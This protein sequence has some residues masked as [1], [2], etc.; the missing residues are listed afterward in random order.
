M[1]MNFESFSAFKTYDFANDSTGIEYVTTSGHTI[2]GIGAAQ[3][4]KIG[5]GGTPNTGNEVQLVTNDGS[6]WKI[7]SY[8]IS[9]QHFGALEVNVNNLPPNTRQLNTL[10]INNFL[11][12]IANNNLGLASFAGEYEVDGP[13]F[14]DC[15]TGSTTLHF[16]YTRHIV[17]SPIIRLE[18]P[19][20]APIGTPPYPI[21]AAFTIFGFKNAVWDGKIYVRLRN[22]NDWVN[23]KCVHG[24]LISASGR[25]T[26]G[27]FYCKG[28]ASFGLLYTSHVLASGNTSLANLGDC[29]F[30]DC[31]SGY[32]KVSGTDPRYMMGNWDNKQVIQEDEPHPTIPGEIITST[33]YT[34][35]I[36]NIPDNIYLEGARS[37]PFLLIGDTLHYVRKFFDNNQ[38]AIFP[39]VDDNLSSGSLKWIFGGGIGLRGSDAN[40]THIK[41]LD[42]TNCSIGLDMMSVYGPIVQRL[43]SQSCFTSACFGL[44]HD[45]TMHSANIA[46]LYCEGNYSEFIPMVTAARSDGSNHIGTEYALKWENVKYLKDRKADNSLTHNGL[47]GYTIVM[48]GQFLSYQKNHLNDGEKF[49]FNIN[50]KSQ[51]EIYH[52][53]HSRVTLRARERLIEPFGYN[54][55]QLTFVGTGPNGSPTGPITLTPDAGYT[56]NGQTAGIVYQNFSGP[57]IFSIFLDTSNGGKNF[58]VGVSN[59][60]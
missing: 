39:R 31:G 59:K 52:R 17:G 12:Y 15:A 16:P 26:F 47:V 6:I 30:E 9:V 29:K 40:V 27:G 33:Y 23:K 41:S 46:G 11:H 43:V 42:V 60:V 56:L 55:G 49:R 2:E 5:D 18:L 19:A 10:R 38:V 22:S 34:I 7:T 54:G 24:I 48:D 37:H 20:T 28:A 8:P 45:G 4:T 13:L 44:R 57:A 14:M 36:D 35:D 53:D 51:A 21:R 58:L 25:S 32:N 3:Y 1:T 50:S